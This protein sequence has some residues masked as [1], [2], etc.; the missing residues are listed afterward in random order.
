MNCKMIVSGTLVKSAAST[1]AN[2]IS[3]TTFSN[4][5]LF[6][7]AAW[8]I[9]STIFTTYSTTGFLKFDEIPKGSLFERKKNRL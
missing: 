3:A 9:S 1:A 8:I 2:V 5:K 4:S 6:V 7:G